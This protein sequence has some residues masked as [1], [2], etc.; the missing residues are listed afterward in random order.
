MAKTSHF[1][2]L[3][4]HYD[5][6]TKILMM[7]TYGRVRKK[8]VST[9]PVKS[10]LDLCCGT[11][12]VT[13]HINSKTVVALDLSHGMLRVNRDKNRDQKQVKYVVGDAFALPFPDRSF[14][15]VYNTLAAHEFKNFSKI[16]SEVHR[17]LKTK[18]EFVLYD[19]S[20]PQNILLRYTYLPFLKHI[21]ELGTFF[22][23]DKEAWE[24]VLKEAGFK[25][26]KFETLYWASILIR[27]RK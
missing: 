10:A 15:A 3:A 20:L 5:F 11:G 25:D 7:G 12:Y 14:D 19:F 27:A 2:R 26:I 24:K 8:I 6:L 21:V 23:S 16:L 13:G 4:R 18:G 1:E 17:V 22:V 9:P